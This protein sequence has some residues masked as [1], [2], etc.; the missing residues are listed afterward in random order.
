MRN[1]LKTCV[2]ILAYVIRTLFRLFDRRPE[3]VVLMYHSI[4][5]TNWKLAITPEVFEKQISYIARN[6]TIVSAS[7]VVAYVK[8]EK[9]L[10]KDSVALTFDDGY[11]DFK[12]EAYPILKKYNAQAAM[13]VPTDT[14]RRIN[15]ERTGLMTWDDMRAIQKEGLVT[16]ESHSRTHPHLP[17]L[18]RDAL[19]QEVRGSMEDIQRELGVHTRFFGYPYGDKSQTVIDSVKKVG[20]EAAFSITEGVVRPGDNPFL[21]KRVQVDTTMHCMLFRMRLTCATDIVRSILGSF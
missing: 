5:R 9:E 16:F 15:P 3:V 7:D 6:K 13:F 21:I 20:Y 4:D 14:T 19:D 12:T 2:Y 17:H 8:G 1:V 10:T 11:L 18:D